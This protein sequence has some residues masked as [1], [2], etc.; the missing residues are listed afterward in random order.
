MSD[1]MQWALTIA[2][3]GAAIIEATGLLLILSDLRD[4]RVA[5]RTWTQWPGTARPGA[6]ATGVTMPPATP[7]SGGGPPPLEQRVAAN[8]DKLEQV[9][10]DLAEY[11]AKSR[12]ELTAAVSDLAERLGADAQDRASRTATFIKATADTRKTRIGTGLLVS[13]LAVNAIAA[14]VAVWG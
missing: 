3:A 9:A 10:A 7:S 6:I 12:K 4:T 11:K 5:L 8:E 1:E 2:F 13:G 14:I